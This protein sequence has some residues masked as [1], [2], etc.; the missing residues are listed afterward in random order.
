MF[1]TLIQTFTES[2]LTLCVCVCVYYIYIYIY[3]LTDSCQ[4]IG[5]CLREK[6]CIMCRLCP[7]V[8]LLLCLGLHSKVTHTSYHL[9]RGLAR[10]RVVRPLWAAETRGV[11]WDITEKMKNLNN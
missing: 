10:E 6:R 11:K 1:H 7:S 8:C 5:R 4:I 3:I 9:N 2:T